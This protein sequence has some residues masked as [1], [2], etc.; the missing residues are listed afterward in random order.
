ML[1]DP[2]GQAIPAAVVLQLASMAHGI[3]TN[4]A[5]YVAAQGIK[6]EKITIGG[7]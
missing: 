1:I 2:R 5:A 6:Q 4:V 7:T 3:V